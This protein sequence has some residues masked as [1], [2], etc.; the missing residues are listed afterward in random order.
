MAAVS[1]RSE[2]FAVAL[3]RTEDEVPATLVL[4]EG[5]PTFEVTAPVGVLT[6][7][8]HTS[9]PKSPDPKEHAEREF[10]HAR[11]QMLRTVRLM[12]HNGTQIGLPFFLAHS[13]Q[14]YP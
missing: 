5:P 4:A 14:I 9:I 13:L 8:G 7:L 3:E 10:M 12:R 1:P 11:H 2:T 6:I